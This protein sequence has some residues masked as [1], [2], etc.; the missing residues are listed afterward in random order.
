VLVAH[1]HGIVAQAKLQKPSILLSLAHTDAWLRI[2]LTDWDRQPQ[3]C[4]KTLLLLW[5]RVATYL[6]ELGILAIR[7][8]FK[9]TLWVVQGTLLCTSFANI[10]VHVDRQAIDDIPRCCEWKDID[11]FLTVL[12]NRAGKQLLA[13]LNQRVVQGQSVT[14]ATRDPVSFR[15][16][17]KDWILSIDF[18][19][20][21][22]TVLRVSLQE[23][24]VVC[25]ERRICMQSEMI[26]ILQA[27]Y[28]NVLQFTIAAL[29]KSMADALLV[30]RLGVDYGKIRLGENGRARLVVAL[31]QHRRMNHLSRKSS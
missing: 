18:C 11:F 25:T 1:I 6:N 15:R 13:I 12:I 14:L 8:R 23:R 5:E 24:V 22:W 7:L 29:K 21:I 9:V 17:A 4:L 27:V 16:I 3:C 20:A 2:D 19:R 26:S 10:C 30:Y 31:V 28:C